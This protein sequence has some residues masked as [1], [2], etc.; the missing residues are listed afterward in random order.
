M[1]DPRKYEWWRLSGEIVVLT[2]LNRIYP[3]TEFG[4]VS[5]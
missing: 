1:G 2:M 3:M 4:R 5:R